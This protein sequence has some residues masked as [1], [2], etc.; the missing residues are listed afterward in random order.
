[1]T[2]KKEFDLFAIKEFLEEYFESKGK[3]QD[4][5]L[6]HDRPKSAVFKFL[7]SEI[8]D[9]FYI[10]IYKTAHA[11]QSAQ[12]E[13]EALSI[14]TKAFEGHDNFGVIFPETFIPAHKAFVSR[15]FIGQDLY[16]LFKQASRPFV[17][18]G[19]KNQSSNA[20]RNL[21]SWL[22]IFQQCHF[23]NSSVQYATKNLLEGTDAYIDVAI[24]KAMVPEDLG[25]R[26][27]SIIKKLAE[28]NRHWDSTLV[29]SNGDTKLWN[30]LADDDGAIKALDFVAIA[31]GLPAMD[32]ARIWIGLNWLRNFPFVQKSYIDLL[33]NKLLEQAASNK[34]FERSQFE[35]CRLC[36]SWEVTAFYSGIRDDKYRRKLRNRLFFP[37]IK[38]YFNHKINS[39]IVE[40]ESCVTN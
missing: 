5:V 15:E 10:K 40:A 22:E 16:S 37:L 26:S 1:V 38:R 12:K 39:I 24:D 19:L 21:A 13:H 3:V 6:W 23:E 30:F 11:T 36:V 31:Y 9:Y 25:I 4:L 18:K 20:I 27:K 34:L 8:D 28:Q 17:S 33:Q 14:M 2:N 32:Y 29:P 7:V 35:F